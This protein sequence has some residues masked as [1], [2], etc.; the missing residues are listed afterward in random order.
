MLFNISRSK[1][2]QTINFGKLIECNIRKIFLDKSCT[3]CSEE[4][5]PRPFYK[6]QN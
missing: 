4:T 2:N 5:I 6:N 3:K 1:D